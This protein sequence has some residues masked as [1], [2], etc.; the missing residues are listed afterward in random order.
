MRERGTFLVCYRTAQARDVG[1]VLPA[2]AYGQK[3]G[4]VTVVTERTQLLSR[5]LLPYSTG[6]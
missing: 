1:T 4:W 5:V 2:L 6:A 3:W